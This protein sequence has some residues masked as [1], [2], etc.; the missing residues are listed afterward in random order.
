V[1]QHTTNCPGELSRNSEAIAETED[2]DNRARMTMHWIAPTLLATLAACG[3]SGPT[4]ESFALVPANNGSAAPIAVTMTL[5]GGWKTT[6]EAAE[7]VFEI[8][9]LPSGSRVSVAALEFTGSPDAMMK[10]AIAGAGQSD[11][12]R[13]DL[14][15]GRVWIQRAT[16][17]LDA[18]LFVPYAKGVLA[19]VAIIGDPATDKLPEIR[20]AFETLA[21][22]R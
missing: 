7:P 9:G 17:V 20:K 16:R 12:Q 5:P 2:R 22:V 18:R 1:C 6:G 13:T 15:G 10:K 11:G 14:P 19:A 8:P 3:S 21:V 4:T